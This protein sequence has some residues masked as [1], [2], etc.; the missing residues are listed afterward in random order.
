MKKILSVLLAVIV[1]ASTMSALTVTASAASTVYD[2]NAAICYA[3]K[4]YNDGKGQCA[5][6]VSDCLRAGGFT[7][8]YSKNAKQ[9]GE[10]LQK[11][12]KTIPCNNWS[13]KSSLKAK[14]FNELLSKGDI[15]IWVNKSGSGSS[16]HAML[17][18]GE[19]DSQGN[20]LVYAH[21][22]AKNKQKITPSSNANKLYAI[23]LTKSKIVSDI[24]ISNFTTLSTLTYG[25]TFS[26]KA[27]VKSSA[28]RIYSVTGG[29]YNSNGSSKIYEKTVYP[30]SYS[31][32]V[33]GSSVDNALLFNKLPVGTYIYRIVARDT[34]GKTVSRSCKF[35]VKNAN[36]S[37]TGNSTKATSTLTINLTQAPAN[38]SYGK[39]FGLRGTV[40]SN[41][42]IT[43]VNGY[44]I[45]SN[46]KTVQ[47]T[48]D[49]PNAK[50]LNIRYAN[51]NNNLLFNKL[52]RGT[53]RLRIV[54]TDTSGT[55]RAIT[56]SFNVK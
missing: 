18:S 9:L 37:V 49:N 31:Y 53:Y 36:S 16:G 10:K 13:S 33:A 15:I 52:P 32:N 4:H 41:Y 1:I 45:D 24:R 43:S 23:H 54:A 19:T 50:S 40:T 46:G 42:N 48:T 20:V 25:K 34:S 8:V 21:N 47:S 39:C 28:Y 56:R 26:A 6:F 38:V 44:I 30:N 5:E 29:I 17:Y 14:G 27:T 12:G 51:L 55:S 22:A 7:A 11:Y 3:Q 2:A 35:T